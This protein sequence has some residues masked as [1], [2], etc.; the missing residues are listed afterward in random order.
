MTSASHNN[1]EHREERLS[2]KTR[3]MM[4]TSFTAR[5]TQQL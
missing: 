1:V 3:I 4:S 2:P 5:G